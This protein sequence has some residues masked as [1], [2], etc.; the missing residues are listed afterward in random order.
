MEGYEKD[1]QYKK[2]CAYGFL[3][4]Q[5]FYE[6]FMLLY[7]LHLGISYLQIGIL[8][9]IREILL[10]LFEIPAGFLSDT[11]GRKKTMITSFILYIFCFI[12][13]S[14]G[15]S[16]GIFILAFIFYALG[17]AFRTGTH[18]AMIYD[19][20]KT[21]GWEAYKVDYYGQTRSWSQRGSALS[22]LIAGGIIFLSGAYRWVFILSI[23]PAFLDLLL[24]ASYP[25][26]LDGKA[27]VLN[28][29]ALG[30]TFRT[31]W[32]D[33]AESFRR[34]KVLRAIVNTSVY[35][36]YYK[37]LK[38]F[39]Q[40]VIQAMALSLPFFTTEPEE[41][42]TAVIVG[43]VYFIL[44]LLTSW[45]SRNASSLARRFSSTAGALNFTLLAGLMAGFGSGILLYFGY[46][47]L[48]VLFYVLLYMIENGRKPIGMGYAT[49]YIKHE[50]LATAL[51]AE[52]QLKTIWSAVL[53][54]ITG[55]IADRFSLS[56]ALIAISTFLLLLYPL[57]RVTVPSP[58]SPE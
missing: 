32:K 1:W 57:L 44:Y 10:N 33:F 12:L 30:E 41:K 6:S 48:A 22:S 52:S 7:F 45:S 55:F 56:L 4:N 8:Y 14:V 11:L 58:K 42:R 38:D 37:A 46:P 43:I 13:F 3:K 25:K 53:I 2:F 49:D 40:P 27:V 9:S 51:S 5:R 26:A 17:D 31:T 16:F 35:S 34:P 21:K 23:L 15:E 19:Y 29:E 28:K 39:L 47:V 36:G 20:L 18:K 54:F 24:L 50:V